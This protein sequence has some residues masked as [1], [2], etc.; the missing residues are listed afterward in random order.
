MNFKVIL[1]SNIGKIV[2]SILLG[3]GVACLFH[4]VC[5]DKECITFA[6][7]VISNVDGKIFKHDNKCYTYNLH[8][9]KCDKNKKI[10]DFGVETT[11]SNIWNKITTSEN[12]SFI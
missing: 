10:V 1:Y 7:P 4:K 9:V 3:L 5:K 8:S 11:Q 12:H 6:G 2:I